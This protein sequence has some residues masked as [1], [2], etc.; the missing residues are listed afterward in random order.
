MSSPEDCKQWTQDHGRGTLYIHT[1][2]LY[3]T[4]T[5]LLPRKKQPESTRLLRHI[6]QTEYDPSL[7]HVAE[8]QSHRPKRQTG[9]CV[10]NSV[11]W[12]TIKSLITNRSFAKKKRQKKRKKEIQRNV[13]EPCYRLYSVRWR[14]PYQYNNVDHVIARRVEEQ[15]KGWYHPLCQRWSY[16]TPDQLNQR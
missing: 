15:R 11:Y 7:Q 5:S 9:K 8:H 3:L 13:Q 10:A 16:Q 14:K 1:P 4:V 2:S 12:Q 6:H